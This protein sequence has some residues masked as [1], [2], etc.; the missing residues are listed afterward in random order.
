MNANPVSNKLQPRE[1]YMAAE[2]LVEF[3]AKLIGK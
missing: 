1:L 2:G 3:F